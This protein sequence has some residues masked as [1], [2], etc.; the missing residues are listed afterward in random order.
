MEEDRV[1]EGDLRISQ[2]VKQ[3]QLRQK[4]LDS[5][6]AFQLTRRPS[7]RGEHTGTASLACSN[8][9]GEGVFNHNLNSRALTVHQTQEPLVK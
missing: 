9:L 3:Q 4:T 7:L 1:A 6:T 2:S 5:S 8:A